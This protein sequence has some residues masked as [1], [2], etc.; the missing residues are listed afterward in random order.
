MRLEECR[1][2]LEELEAAREELLKVLREM[3]IHSTKSIALIHAGKVEEAEQE[4]KKAIEL[5]EKVK[6][7]REYPE[8][9][10]YL[11]NDAMQEL[12]EAIAFKNAISGEFTF[13]IDLEVTPAAFLNGFAD[14]VGELRRYALTKLIEGDF[15]SA[16]RMLEVMEKIYERLMEFTT[17]PDKLVSGLRKKLDVARGGIERTKSDYIAA[18]VARLNESLGGN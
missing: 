2:R 3:R 5:L 17:F 14:A 1:K 6:A 13:E 18:K 4:L 11:C 12:V 15:K 7:Y 8:I 10:F 16:E 9:Y